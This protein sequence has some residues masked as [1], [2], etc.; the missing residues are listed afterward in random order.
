MGN[1]H[2][3][4]WPEISWTLARLRELAVVLQTM[5]IVKAAEILTV[6][7][8]INVTRGMIVNQVQKCGNKKK[9]VATYAPRGD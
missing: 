5:S 8:K 7:W 3:Q 2:S 9:F 4:N 6:Q 1:I